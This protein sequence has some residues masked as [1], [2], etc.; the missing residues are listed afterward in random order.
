MN[1]VQ[2]SFLWIV[3]RWNGTKSKFNLPL[4]PSRRTF[5]CQEGLIPRFSPIA[6]CCIM[7]IKN[8]LFRAAIGAASCIRHIPRISKNRLRLAPV[9]IAP[10]QLG[11]SSPWLI[12]IATH[13]PRFQPEIQVAGSF[14]I[15]CHGLWQR[16]KVELRISVPIGKF[17]EAVFVQI[18]DFAPR[19]AQEIFIANIGSIPCLSPVIPL[20]VLQS[21]PLLLLLLYFLYGILVCFEIASKN[22]PSFLRYL[23]ANDC[24]HCSTI[25]F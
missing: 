15:G 6:D 16:G 22:A 4:V 24:R 3:A 8:F 7:K 1:C 14:D 13:G 25:L 21:A 5:W 17:V 19:R 2:L 18:Q 9:N 12:E 11:L 20:V 23:I 10:E